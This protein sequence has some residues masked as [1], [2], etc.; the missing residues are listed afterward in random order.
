M[1][2]TK[3]RI[4]FSTLLAATLLFA[5]LGLS[6]LFMNKRVSAD[7][8]TSKTAYNVTNIEDVV[9]TYSDMSS[10]ILFGTRSDGGIFSYEKF[11]EVIGSSSYNSALYT[12]ASTNAAVGDSAIESANKYK[13]NLSY[14]SDKSKSISFSVKVPKNTILSYRFTFNS[15]WVYSLSF[16]QSY[17]DINSNVC[18]MNDGYYATITPYTNASNLSKIYPI[19]K[20]R[21]ALS[22][23]SKDVTIIKNWTPAFCETSSTSEDG[24]NI[25]NHTH[26][27]EDGEECTIIYGTYEKSDGSLDIVFIL[28]NKT[29]KEVF[30]AEEVKSNSSKYT[31][32]DKDSVFYKYSDSEYVYMGMTAQFNTLY[33]NHYGYSS[34]DSGY[35]S[36]NDLILNTSIAG[37]NRP[38][39]QD[40]YNTTVS[41]KAYYEGDSAATVTLPSGY[42]LVDNTATLV[43]GENN[44]AATYA[45]NDYYGKETTVN[46]T[47]KVTAQDTNKVTLKNSKGTVIDTEYLKQSESNYTL[48]NADKDSGLADENTFVGWFDNENKLYPA[49]YTMTITGDTELTLAEIS[50]TLDGAYLR[51]AENGGMRYIA[52]LASDQKTEILNKSK[53]Y[54]VIL[55]KDRITDDIASAISDTDKV[56]LI[57][58]NIKVDADGQSNGYFALTNILVSN[59][60]RTFTAT[61]YLEVSYDNDTTGKIFTETKDRSVIEIAYAAYNS[62]DVS[63]DVKA[64]VKETYLEKVVFITENEGTIAAAENIT[65][66]IGGTST[67]VN[68]VKKDGF[69]LSYTD[70]TLKI[71]GLTYSASSDDKVHIPIIKVESEGSFVEMLN[72]ATEQDGGYVVT[73]NN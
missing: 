11:N 51:V 46:C 53:W 60:S 64:F 17:R 45:I 6:T 16:G 31:A 20:E 27:I 50:F 32:P 2:K 36:D 22:D 19:V 68:V 41:D 47:V 55:P 34:G 39:A 71:S 63:E 25:T 14:S 30:S 10:D 35:V 5:S 28:K 21:R 29:G 54:G 58:D 65:I 24:Q 43:A 69:S 15:K 52:Q 62:S 23:S 1:K 3:Q 61:S 42:A 7:D 59:Y 9:S 49:G 18:G 13:G 4:L 38:I 67:S 57:N 72:T 56:E 33:N 26:M 66:S 40:V 8:D 37:I 70:S 48:I 12:D 44:L 73:F